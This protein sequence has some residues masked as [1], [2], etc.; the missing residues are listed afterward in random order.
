[1]P[2]YFIEYTLLKFPSLKI[3]IYF[4]KPMPSVSELQL[5]DS[6]KRLEILMD[7]SSNIH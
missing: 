7:A 5:A 2:E 4:L 6:D 1:M 3:N